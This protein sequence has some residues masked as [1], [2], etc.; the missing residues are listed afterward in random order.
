M[1]VKL[2]PL[3]DPIVKQLFIYTVIGKWV[4]NIVRDWSRF[5]MTSYEFLIN[6]I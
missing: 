4:K 1:Q 5:N 2:D 3:V 6:L